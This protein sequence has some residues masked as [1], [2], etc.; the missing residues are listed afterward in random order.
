[1]KLLFAAV[2]ALLL[3]LN[4]RHV[5]ARRRGDRQYKL[6]VFGDEFADTGNYPLADL[7]K[8]T[9]AWYYPYGS[10]DKDHGT[11]PSGRF[12]NGLVLSDFVARIMGLK[13]SPPAERKREQNGVDPS[14]MNF[15]VGGAGVV[16]GTHEAPKL[17]TQID[18][19][20]RMVRHGIIDKDLTD[21]VALIAFSGKRDYARAADMTSSE[22]TAMAQDVTDKMASAVE[23]LTDLGVEKVLVS[24]LPPLGCTP[25]LSR[26]PGGGYDGSCDSQ[27][28]A[29]VHN[30]YLE[31]KVFKDKAVFNLDLKTMFKRLTA[32]SGSSSKQ[33][34]YKQEPCCE[35]ID[36]AGYCGQMDGGYAQYS[37][38][39]KPDKYFYWDEI[40]PTQAGW[41]A[42][43]EELEESI[44]N[45]LDIYS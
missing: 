15:A 34:K 29:S 32:S 33:F 18:K 36:Q 11:S 3:L 44:K 40:N 26:S 14:G 42:V 12:S 22:V 9:L 30:A 4:A 38:C 16:E 2:C 27:K 8:T 45:F 10:N 21:S 28:V 1:M 17:G 5:E 37:L 39:Y 13:E 23:Q 41:K 43:V 6:F 20:R 25:W 35:S 31:E 7:T 24:T 19:F